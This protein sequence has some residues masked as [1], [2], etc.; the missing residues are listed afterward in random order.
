[1]TMFFIDT[2]RPTAGQ[3]LPQGLWFADPIEGIAQASLDQ[4]VDA[5]QLS[6]VLALPVDGIFPGGCRPGQSLNCRHW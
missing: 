1:M 3:V 4:L 5:P 6:S 2:A